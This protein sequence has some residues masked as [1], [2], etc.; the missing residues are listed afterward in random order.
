M[1]KISTVAA[2][3][4]TRISQQKLTVGLDLGDRRKLRLP[5]PSRCPKGGLPK[6]SAESGFHNRLSSSV[7]EDRA[8]LSGCIM[9]VAATL[10]QKGAETGNIPRRNRSRYPPFEKRKGWGSLSCGGVGTERV[11]QPA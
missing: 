1:K 6:A 10:P 3:T 2:K 5:H 7:D 9:K 4:S 8:E 11:G